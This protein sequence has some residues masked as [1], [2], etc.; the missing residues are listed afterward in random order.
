MLLKMKSLA[1]WFFLLSTYFVAETCG[2][3]ANMAVG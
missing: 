3:F 2:E 1:T